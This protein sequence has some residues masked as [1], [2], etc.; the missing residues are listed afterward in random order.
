MTVKAGDDIPADQ[1]RFI[2]WASRHVDVL[3]CDAAVGGVELIHTNP[4]AVCAE[5]ERRSRKARVSC[6]THDATDSEESHQR[7]PHPRRTGKSHTSPP[8]A[9]IYCCHGRIER[10]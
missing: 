8:A 3:E 10:R 5:R 6:Q 4:R 9:G 1:A 7:N 2:S